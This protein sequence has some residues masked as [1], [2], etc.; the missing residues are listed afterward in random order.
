[1]FELIQVPWSPYCLVIRRIL[2]YSGAPHKIINVPP[3]DRSLIWRLTR[4][5][6]YQVPVLKDG[7]AIVFETDANSQVIAKY[8]ES[9]LVLGLFPRAW[10]GIQ[11]ILWRYVENDVEEMTFKL[12]DAHYMEFVPP[13]EQLNYLRFKE[14]KFGRGCLAEWRTGQKQL[15]AELAGRLMPFEQMLAGRPFLLGQTPVFLDFDLHGM[16]ANFLHSGHYKLPA[17]HPKLKSWYA[18]IAQAEK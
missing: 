13:A 2:E 12:N 8:L 6:Y 15:Q 11:K 1:M 16:L 3:S 4:R 9:K 14:R 7:R 17:A 10:D 18:R 5:R